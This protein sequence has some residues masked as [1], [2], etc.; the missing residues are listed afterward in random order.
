ML[1]NKMDMIR[2][3]KIDTNS[4]W[5]VFRRVPGSVGQ[6]RRGGLCSGLDNRTR[7]VGWP[8]LTVSS[9]QGCGGGGGGRGC[10]VE[11]WAGQQDQV[12]WLAWPDCILNTRMWGGW[13]GG[14]YCCVEGWAGQ[15]DQVCWL[16]RP[17]CI[18]YTRM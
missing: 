12:C 13:G 7:C 5:P 2:Y 11:G 17:D 1:Y 16:D 15:Q 4:L 10:C 8:G 9:T 14:Y 18:L 6:S 3:S